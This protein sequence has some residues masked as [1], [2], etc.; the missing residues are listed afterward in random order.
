MD[1]H[2]M[3]FVGYGFLMAFLKTHSWTSVAYNMIVGAY[4]LQIT[5]LFQGLWHQLFIKPDMDAIDYNPQAA[6]F[7]KISLSVDSVILGDFG[8]AAVLVSL[9][10][11]IGKCSIF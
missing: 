11:I 8:A 3:V 9:G 5:I 10:A 2:L 4:A 7:N 1:V 6:R